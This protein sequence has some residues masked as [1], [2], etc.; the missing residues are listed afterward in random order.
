MNE[1]TSELN[2]SKKGKLV[3][4]NRSPPCRY[5]NFPNY[6]LSKIKVLIMNSTLSLSFFSNVYVLIISKP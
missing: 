3:Y 4:E 6:V 2:V 5:L 1:F